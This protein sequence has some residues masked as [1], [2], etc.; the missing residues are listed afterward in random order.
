MGYVTI[1]AD[2]V[3]PGDQLPDRPGRT[4]IIAL[5]N[6]AES[7]TLKWEKDG[8]E[9]A[10]IYLSADTPVHVWRQDDQP[11]TDQPS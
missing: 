9:L 2:E 1:R 10:G 3:R 8:G 7:I 4:I 6:R 5:C 11:G